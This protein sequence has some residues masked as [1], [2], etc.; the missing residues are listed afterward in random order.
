MEAEDIFGGR[1]WSF[2]PKAAAEEEDSRHSKIHVQFSHVYLV[3]R[4]GL[5]NDDACFELFER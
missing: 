5:H 4:S 3:K 2:S 1:K